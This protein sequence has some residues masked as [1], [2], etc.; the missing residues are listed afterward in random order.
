MEVGPGGGEAKCSITSSL[1]EK[2]KPH[3]T[4]I[5]SVCGIN[6]SSRVHFKP[7]VWWHILSSCKSYRL[8]P[9]HPWLVLRI[10]GQAKVSL[11]SL[12]GAETFT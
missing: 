7:P 8:T 6:T 12:S 3:S 11:C 2:K 10:M 4:V 5:A 9:A 1:K